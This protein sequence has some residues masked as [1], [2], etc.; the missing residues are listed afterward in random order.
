M[1]SKSVQPGGDKSI[2]C[3]QFKRVKAIGKPS[4]NAIID[5]LAARSESDYD[6]KRIKTQSDWLV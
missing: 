1:V 4:G 6:V 3:P 2:Y 5:A